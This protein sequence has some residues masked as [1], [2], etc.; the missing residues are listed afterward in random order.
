MLNGT[1][2]DCQCI[3]YVIQESHANRNSILE[4]IQ[5]YAMDLQHGW[6]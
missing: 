6:I 3:E 4:E 5:F 2:Q 1:Y